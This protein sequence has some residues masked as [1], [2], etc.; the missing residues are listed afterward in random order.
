MGTEGSSSDRYVAAY[1]YK[2]ATVG[3]VAG[4]AGGGPLIVGDTTDYITLTLT[5]LTGAL[6]SGIV[7]VGAETLDISGRGVNAGLAT[8]T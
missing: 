5:A 8:R 2:T 6:T 4:G 1:N 7:V 3:A